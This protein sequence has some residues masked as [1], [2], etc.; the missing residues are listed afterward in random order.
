MSEMIDPQVFA[1][2]ARLATTEWRH[3]LRFRDMFADD[4]TH[5]SME[6]LLRCVTRQ[7]ERAIRGESRQ[8]DSDE[9]PYFISQLESLKSDF[10]VLI[11][12]DDMDIDDLVEEFDYRLDE[13]YN[14]GDRKIQLRDGRLQKFAWIG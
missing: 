8:V 10:D 11:S 4:P 1:D 5:E 14:L 13:L 12:S 7:I 6:S 2:H 9:S 3:H